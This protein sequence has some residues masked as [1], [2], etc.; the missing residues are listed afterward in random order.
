MKH[1]RRT[2][3]HTTNNSPVDA[4]MSNKTT[5]SKVNTS[6]S[7]EI[8]KELSQLSL[9]S[10]QEEALNSNPNLIRNSTSFKYACMS[11]EIR[12]NSQFCDCD[13]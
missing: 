10:S 5:A 12:Q 6:A 11:D 8:M 1:T 2:N 13:V 3:F 9:T 7:K 4:V